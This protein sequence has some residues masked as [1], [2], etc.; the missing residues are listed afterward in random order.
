MPKSPRRSLLFAPGDSV[1]KMAKVAQVAPDAVIL[2]LED[3]VAI[4]QKERARQMVVEA[5]VEM[6][7]GRTERLVRINGSGTD[8]YAADLAVMARAN[9]EGLVAP[10]I[11]FPEQV[12]HID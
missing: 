7:F 3:A 9:L 10:K 4:G 11:E 6:D 5:L 12:Q 1:T 2:D 8:F